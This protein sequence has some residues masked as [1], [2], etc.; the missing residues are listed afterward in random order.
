MF[1]C[2]KDKWQNSF[3]LK[4]DLSKF[5]GGILNEYTFG[6]SFYR[7][8]KGRPQAIKIGNKTAYKVSDLVEW[9]DAQPIEKIEDKKSNK[10]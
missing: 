5:T 8:M 2:L 4:K 1:E 7:H 3:V 6:S 9:L 10:C